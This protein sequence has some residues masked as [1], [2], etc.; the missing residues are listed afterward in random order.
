MSEQKYTAEERQVISEYA[1][2][3]MVALII[4]GKNTGTIVVPENAF[5]YGEAMLKQEKKLFPVRW[6]K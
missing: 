4:Q 3:A 2:W 1:K 6:A 5:A